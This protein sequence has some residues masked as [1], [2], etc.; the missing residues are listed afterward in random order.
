MPFRVADRLQAV[1]EIVIVVEGDAGIDAAE[2]EPLEQM[3]LP[4]IADVVID[5]AALAP[6]RDVSDVARQHQQEAETAEQPE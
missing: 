6:A 4:Q 5:A 1:L 3:R 2:A